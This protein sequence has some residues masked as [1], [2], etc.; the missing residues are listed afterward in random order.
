M[1]A[2]R[3][4]GST[5]NPKIERIDKELERN[6]A[7]ISELQAKNRELERQKTELENVEIIAL[8]R[9][10]QGVKGTPEDL[11][12]LLET[13]RGASPPSTPE[14]NSASLPDGGRLSDS[15][16]PTTGYPGNT[17]QYEQEDNH[18]G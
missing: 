15:P 6:R 16:A 8:V 2:C 9:G 18:E 11:N 4:G 13:L 7:K 14:P 17:T 1:R 12:A 5:I 10:I 3:K